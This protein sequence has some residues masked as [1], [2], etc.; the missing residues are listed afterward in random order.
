MTS[1][2]ADTSAVHTGSRWLDRL[3]QTRFTQL[4]A[5]LSLLL[6]LA[7]LASVLGAES[8]RWIASWLVVASLSFVLLAAAAAVAT[9]RKHML[10]TLSLATL[11]FVA[12]MARTLMTESVVIGIVEGVLTAVYLTYVVCLIVQALFRQRLVT[13]DM[14]AA[15]LCGYLLI[16]V[17]YSVIYSLVIEFDQG[18]VS[19]NSQASAEF[20]DIHFGDHRT[21]SSLYF[22][23]V[24][25]TTLGYGD[26]TPVSITAR[27]LTASEALIG[28]LYLTVLVARLVALQIAG[29]LAGQRTDPPDG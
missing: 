6:L 26:L 19:V 18:A 2:E 1:P 10:T 15:S 17:I 20:E 29:G 3:R 24:T 4:L 23:F 25:L 22:S 28:Q 21:A 13:F 9:T 16:G 11:C 27:M 8:T 5:A 7:P 14:I 12:L